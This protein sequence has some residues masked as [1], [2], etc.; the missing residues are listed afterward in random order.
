MNTPE[1]Q[2]KV[3]AIQNKWCTDHQEPNDADDFRA[4]PDGVQLKTKQKPVEHLT[5]TDP[6]RGISRGHRPQ[7]D[8]FSRHQC[9]SIAQASANILNLE[10]GIVVLNDLIEG[11]TLIE[12]LKDILHSNA[13]AGYTR[14]AK[15]DVGVDFNSLYHLTTL[16]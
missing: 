2:E 15:M 5:L 4:I 8:I 16:R 12:Q 10:I 7:M 13:R 6:L 14:L 11:E 1:P 3:N 9:D